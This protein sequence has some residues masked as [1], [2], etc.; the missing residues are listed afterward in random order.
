MVSDRNIPIFWNLSL[1]LLFPLTRIPLLSPDKSH[2]SPPQ[3]TLHQPAHRTVCFPRTGCSPCRVLTPSHEGRWPVLVI[4]LP[5]SLAHPRC[6]IHVRWMNLS[7]FTYSSDGRKMT[8]LCYIGNIS[9]LN[10]IPVSI[11]PRQDLWG[12][13]CSSFCNHKGRRGFPGGSVVKNLLPTQQHAF[14]PWIRK[15]PW[16]S[17]WQPTPVLL[18]G[19]SYG[20]NSLVGYSPRS[21]KGLDTTEQMSTR[22]LL[23]GTREG[24]R[25]TGDGDQQESLKWQDCLGEGTQEK[26]ASGQKSE[27]N[28]TDDY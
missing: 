15:I 16:R 25:N 12:K 28:T 22:A 27:E 2:L 13:L 14:D 10:G 6:S 24:G 17:K 3:E 11:Q 9:M 21:R 1:F 26:W 5:Q 8:M 4:C 18:P 7:H 19:K 23:S 20:Q